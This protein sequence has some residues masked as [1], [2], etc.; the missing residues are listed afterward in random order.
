MSYPQRAGPAATRQT[1]TVAAA[2][3][4]LTLGAVQRAL[5]RLE[6]VQGLI[7]ARR[8]ARALDYDLLTRLAREGAASGRPED[9]PAQIDPRYL[10]LWGMRGPAVERLQYAL[11]QLGLRCPRS[12]AFCDETLACYLSWLDAETQPA[13]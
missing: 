7:A 3:G 10:L 8:F 2:R 9:D 13:R 5:A 6:R 12:G 1:A 11:E 4:A